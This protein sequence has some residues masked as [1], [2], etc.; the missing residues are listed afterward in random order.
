MPANCGILFVHGV[1]AGNQRDHTTGPDHVDGFR[2]EVVVNGSGQL[3]TAAVRRIVHRII[4]ERYISDSRV[5]E[6]FR[7][8]RVFECLRVNA[9]IRVEF[10]GD[11]SRNRIKLHA[12]APRAGI[13]TFG[14][15]TK[16][17]PD[18]HR[19][20]EDLCARLESEPLHGLPDRLNNIGRCVVGIRGRGTS[21][22]KLFRAQQFPQFCRDGLP[23]SRRLRRECVRHRAP[24]GVL[25]ERRLFLGRG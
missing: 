3:R 9:R 8:W 18:A 1:A 12:S 2:Q 7:K 17:V 14:H 13:Q 6:V 11:A 20:F 16:E 25:H 24:A 22:R 19:R 21:R 15:Q 5:E 4:A 10:G 23:I